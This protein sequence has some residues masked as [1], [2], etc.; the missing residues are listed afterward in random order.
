MKKESLSRLVRRL[1]SYEAGGV[2]FSPHLPSTHD[3]SGTTGGRKQAQRQPAWSL[4][5]N[6]EGDRKQIATMITI[7]ITIGKGL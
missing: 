4:A 3:A 2:S 5:S 1:C 6:G 7:I